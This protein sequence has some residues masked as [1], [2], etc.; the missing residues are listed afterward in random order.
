MRFQSGA[1]TRDMPADRGALRD[2]AWAAGAIGCD[3][4]EVSD[5]VLGADRAAILRRHALNDAN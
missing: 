1:P 3:G 5:H 2:W 4:V